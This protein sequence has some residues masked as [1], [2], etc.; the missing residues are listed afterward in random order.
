[1]SS[2]KHSQMRCP[3]CGV[4]QGWGDISVVTWFSCR[5]CGA[6][7][8]VPTQRSERLF[9]TGGGMA[10][11]VLCITRPGLWF[12]L[13]LWFPI[14]CVIGGILYIISFEVRRPMLESDA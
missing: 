3:L 7:L 12:S 13:L 4:E 14:A 1:M 8:R 10:I 9:W 11:L 5:D 6:R 2:P